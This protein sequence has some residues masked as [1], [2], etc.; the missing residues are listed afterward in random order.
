METSTSIAPLA[1]DAAYAALVRPDIFVIVCCSESFQLA[2]GHDEIKKLLRVCKRARPLLS[3]KVTRFDSWCRNAGLYHQAEQMRIGLTP[4]DKIALSLHC[5]NPGSADRSWLVAQSNH[6]NASAS[7]LLAR[8]IQADFDSGA[9]VY[10][11]RALRQ[12]QAF[13]LLEAA[14]SASHAMAQFHLAESYRN[15]LGVDQDQTKA[16]ELYRSL[17]EQRMPRAQVAFGRCYES[18]EGVDQNHEAAIEW[19]S[20]AASQGSEDGRL[21]IVFLQGWFSLVGHGVEQSDVDAFNRWQEV[22]TKSTDLAI[23][24][25]ATYMVGWMHYLGRGTLQDRQRGDKILQAN[26]SREFPI[27]E[28]DGLDTRR[29][30]SSNSPTACRFYGLCRLGSIHDRLCRHLTAVCLI[31]GFG[32]IKDQEK[33]ADVFEQL[34]CEGCSDSQYWLAACCSYGWGVAL[35]KSNAFEWLKVSADQGNP[36]GQ[37]MAGVYYLRGIGIEEDGAKAVEC[38]RKSAEQGNRH[39]QYYLGDCYRTASG[40][41]GDIDTAVLWYRRSAEQGLYSAIDE[42]NY[43]GR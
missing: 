15:G 16:A 43:L 17:A 34:A 29:H 30:I 26:V 39:G 25:I 22:S 4:S 27:G 1:P 13:Q 5:K 6:G 24:S 7:Y 31:Q 9:V 28:H 37:Y 33:A 35:D 32:T 23:K 18:G 42:L 38:F 40:V 19:Y 14:A 10:S 12:Q 2:L 41:D 20:K 11:E 8:I 21:H 3:S 36:Y